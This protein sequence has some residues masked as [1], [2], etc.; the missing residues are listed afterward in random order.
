[1]RKSRIARVQVAAEEAAGEGRHPARGPG[2]PRVQQFRR[3]GTLRRSGVS[4]PEQ[5]HPCLAEDVVPGE[6]LVGPLPRHHDLVAVLPHQFREQEQRR[7]R[8]AHDRGLGVPDNLREHR[9]DVGPAHHDVLVLRPEQR[10]DICFWYCPSSNSL[11]E[12]RSENV[13]KGASV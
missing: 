13:C 11:S 7:G 4:R 10:A 5:A 1:M 8:R 9:S 6:D 2:H 12:K 3:P